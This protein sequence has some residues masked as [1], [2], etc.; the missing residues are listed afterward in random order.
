MTAKSPA[1]LAIAF[2]SF[3][4]AGCGSGEDADA[5]DTLDEAEAEATSRAAE[6]GLVPCALAGAEQFGVDCTLD[7]SRT[8]EGLVLTV[9]HP[10]GGFRRLLVTDD[11]RGV[12][13]ADGAEQAVVSLRGD[14]EIEVAIAGDRYR[15]PATVG[16][17]GAGR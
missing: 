12:I 3:A 10:D 8:E 15:L 5:I 14:R 11:G 16:P 13:A 4:L 17:G 1:L 7:R 2:C 6:S 9:R